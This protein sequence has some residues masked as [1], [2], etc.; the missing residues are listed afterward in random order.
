MTRTEDKGLYSDSSTNKKTED[1]RNRCNIIDTSGAVLAVSIHQNSYHQE[2][3]K[4]AQ[5]FFYKQ[6]D[7]GEVLAKCIQESLAEGLDKTNKRQAKSNDSYYLLRK[8]KTP[9]VIVECGFLSNYEEAGKLVGEDYQKQ[10]AK[11]IFNGIEN[12]LKHKN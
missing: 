4:G 11:A 1:M 9:T 3:V 7:E 8:T 10:V 5:V 2:G 12:Y 6:S